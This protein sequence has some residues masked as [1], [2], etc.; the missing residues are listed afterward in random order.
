[1]LPSYNVQIFSNSLQIN[2]Q[3]LKITTTGV[4][5]NFFPCNI[6]KIACN[7]VSGPTVTYF[8]NVNNQPRVF[9]SNLGTFP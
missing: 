8:P 6:F 9:T 5:A 7:N 1:M 4:D 3:I 2:E